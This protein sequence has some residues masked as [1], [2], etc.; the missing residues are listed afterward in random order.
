MYVCTYS[1]TYCIT[2]GTMN[3]ATAALADTNGP[4]EVADR[5]RATATVY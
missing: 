2:F 3:S 4:D 1:L 5:V